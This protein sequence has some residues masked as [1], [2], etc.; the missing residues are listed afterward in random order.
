MELQTETIISSKNTSRNVFT[1]K[2]AS[3]KSGTKNL[4]IN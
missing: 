1:M 4:K 3:R 2:R